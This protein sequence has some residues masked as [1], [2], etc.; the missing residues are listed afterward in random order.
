MTTS[1]QIVDTSSSD[2]WITTDLRITVLR[3]EDDATRHALT[4]A[5][6]DPARSVPP[7]PRLSRVEPDIDPRHRP[8]LRLPRSSP[9]RE[10]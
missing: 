7:P 4:A 9:R 1:K 10:N 3:A 6:T 2:A 5:F 8:A